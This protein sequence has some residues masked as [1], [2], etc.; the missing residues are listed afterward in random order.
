MLVS[1]SGTGNGI[2]ISGSSANFTGNLVENLQ[3]NSSLSVASD[4][5]WSVGSITA[6]S[7]LTFSNDKDLSVGS[8]SLNGSAKMNLGTSDIT[9]SVSNPVSVG[10]TQIIRNGGG[11]FK[12]SGGLTLATG[13]EL[14]GQGQKVSGDIVLNGGKVTAE[15]NTEI[16]NNISVSAD[17]TIQIDPSQALTYGGQA[18]EL[19]ASKLKI[20]GGGSFV[21]QTVP[22]K[23]LSLIHISEPTRPY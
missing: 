11:S 17:S 15:K 6:G 10:D 13:S 16:P 9:V 12:F 1:A 3:L 20:Q 22:I 18:I 2:T 4:V 19:G 8:L 14:V 7:V 5:A 21:T 23:L